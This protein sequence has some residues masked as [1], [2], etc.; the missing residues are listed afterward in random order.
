[1]TP[2]VGVDLERLT[3]GNARLTV[4]LSTAPDDAPRLLGLTLPGD[5]APTVRRSALPVVEVA[6]VDEGRVG[7]SG[8]RHVDGAVSHRLRLTSHE[9]GDGQV[10]GAQAGTLGPWWTLEM[11]DQLSGIEVTTTLSL[12]GDDATLRVSSTVRSTTQTVVVEHVSS[13]VLG[14][15]ASG[16]DWEELVLWQ[17][18]NPWSGE[19]RWQQETLGRRG[20]VDVGMSRFAQVGS[21]NRVSLTS[22]GAWSTSEHLPMGALEDPVSGRVLAWQVESSSTWHWEVADR[23]DDLYLLASGPT[24]L[25][26]GWSV[27]LDPGQ[28]F[29]AVP[30]AVTLVRGAGAGAVGSETVQRAAATTRARVGERG[31]ATAVGAA[32]TTYRRAVRRPHDDHHGLPV[33]YNDFLN[34]LMSDPTTDRVLPLVEASADLGAEIYCMDAGWYDDEGGGWWDSVGEWEPSVARFPGG[35][36]AAVV[37][38][39]HRSG[40]RPGLWLEPEVVGVRSPL[41]R[42]LPADAFFRRHGRR[43]GEW[44]RHQLD[45]RHPA[46]RQHLDDVVDRLVGDFD[47][48][49]LKLDYNV[50]TGAGTQ[51][52]GG[53]GY[54]HGLLEHGRAMLD[55]V[56]SVM[57]RHPGLVVEG[58]AAGGSR[59]DGASGAVFPVQSL[60]DQQDMLLL[61]PIAAA[62][63]LAIPPE[64]A[65]VWA[66]LD[67]GMDDET[68]AFVL[69]SAMT[70]RIHLAGR[71]DTL[72]TSQRDLV[73]TAL[74]TYSQTRAAIPRSLPVWPLG[75][76]S[77]HDDL[78]VSGLRDDRETLLVVHRRGGP[79]SVSIPLPEVSPGARVETIFPGWAAGGAALVNDGGTTSLDLTLPAA[80]SAQVLRVTDV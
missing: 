54:G 40:M 50:D 70:S 46:A 42:T 26:H 36:L 18:A 13:L 61:P 74:A 69:A 3:W 73:R 34:G 44:G 39:I 71:V 27:T 65:G 57:D 79:A 8:K 7:T 6:L 56:T 62:S 41:A 55:W 64:Q 49:Y 25:E 9:T 21:K 24:A 5:E 48:G 28:S 76:P 20:L 72:T 12:P 14:G 45:L 23:Y 78:V 4:H 30:A 17:A 35:G 47:L 63:G 29:T 15:L 43:V 10:P 53:D 11:H 66:S 58:C 80:P 33:V 1:M 38:E 2:E 32:L 59:T 19:F 68:I 16:T 75:L 77:W 22:V 67:G 31:A 52:A 60:T 51:T 37:D